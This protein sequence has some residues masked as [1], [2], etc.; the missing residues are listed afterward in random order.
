M[1][2]IVTCVSCTN[3]H[4]RSPSDGFTEDFTLSHRFH[5]DSMW[6]PGGFLESRWTFDLFFIGVSP[7]NSLSRIHLESSWTPAGVHLSIWTPPQNTGKYE[8][9]KP[10]SIWTPHGL[11]TFYC[12]ISFIIKNK[13]SARA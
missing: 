10:D 8:F 12:I 4:V 3:N 5:V 13:K 1:S 2:H 9:P 6:T 11:I 7:A